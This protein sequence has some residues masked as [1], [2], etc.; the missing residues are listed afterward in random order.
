M[1]KNTRPSTSEQVN[2]TE[3]DQKDRTENPTQQNTVQKGMI[4]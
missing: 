4:D 2:I 3:I 1:D